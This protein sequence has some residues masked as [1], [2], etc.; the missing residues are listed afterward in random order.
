MAKRDAMD[1]DIME[2][3]DRVPLDMLMVDPTEDVGFTSLNEQV[4]KVLFTLS[5]R[6][7]RVLR[8]TGT[9]VP[10]RDKQQPK[11]RRSK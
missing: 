1:G 7:K 10:S 4:I 9:K 2:V 11:R 5:P 8:K 6:E 3:C